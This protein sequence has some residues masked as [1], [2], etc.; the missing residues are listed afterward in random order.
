VKIKPRFLSAAALAK[1]LG[2]SAPTVRNLESK[3]VI[4]PEFRIDSL[5]RYDLAKVLIQLK[6]ART[7]PPSP[8]ALTY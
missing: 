4:S 3:G 2:V 1:E 8:T 7:A 6:D 5:V